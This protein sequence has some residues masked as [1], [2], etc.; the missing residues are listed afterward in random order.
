M[1]AKTPVVV[2]VE[3][4]EKELLYQMAQQ[5]NRSFTDWARLVLLAQARENVLTN[6]QG[7][8]QTDSAYNQ[9]NPTA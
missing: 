3:P 1:N 2:Y 6:Q 9:N 4:S 7:D 8:N 5:D